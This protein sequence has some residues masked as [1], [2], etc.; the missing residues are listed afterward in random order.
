[1][2]LTSSV[3][4]LDPP[5]NIYHPH[6]QR[7]TLCIIF[8]I[9]PMD[10]PPKFVLHPLCRQQRGFLRNGILYPSSGFAGY[11]WLW[12]FTF[13]KFPDTSCTAVFKVT[14]VTENETTSF[15]FNVFEPFEDHCLIF[16]QMA[17]QLRYLPSALARGVL[18]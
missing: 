16:E 8:C 12:Q 13:R 3:D 14:R 9:I 4:P 6:D 18:C 10:E 17:F 15:V 7:I 5:R 1:M 2:C 11:L